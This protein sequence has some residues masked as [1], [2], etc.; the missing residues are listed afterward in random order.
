MSL[1]DVFHANDELICKLYPTVTSSSSQD[2]LL[3][4]AELIQTF[5]LAN[6]FDGNERLKKWFQAK[7]LKPVIEVLLNVN[8]LLM[9][10]NPL[11]LLYV[12]HSTHDFQMTQALLAL[13]YFHEWHS[14]QPVSFNS[15]LRF[16]VLTKERFAG[17]EE[18]PA[19]WL[20]IKFNEEVLAFCD[21]E[22]LCKLSYFIEKL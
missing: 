11:N 22:E 1:L 15:S 14:A 20:R 17:D 9:Q 10:E 6:N 12:T 2:E 18:E 8:E 3:H 16:E 21:N 4:A 13:G 5:I 7:V 19:V